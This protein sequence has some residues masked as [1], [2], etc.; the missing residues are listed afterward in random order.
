M[1]SASTH[2]LA[3]P[4]TISSPR[5]ARRLTIFRIVA[6]IMAVAAVGG[7]V[8]TAVFGIVNPAQAPH[9]FHNAVVAAL[10]IV[11]S[12]PPVIVALRA[13][14]RATRAL[15]ILAVLALAALATMALSLTLDPFT[16]PFVVAIGA[17]WALR[18][19]HGDLIPT[20]RPS[21]LL[22]VLVIAAAAPL[23]TYGVSQAE[24]QRSDHT[25]DHAAFFHWVEASF[26]TVGILLLGVLTALRPAAYRLAGWMAA[27]A[28]A[29]LGAGSLL[30][31]TYAS[32]IETPW[33]WAA[34]GGAIA[35]VAIAEWEARRHLAE[36][37][38]HRL[39]A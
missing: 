17:L 19:P 7:G 15:T 32:A 35:F 11:L 20:G 5:P 4:A 22:L 9:A 37:V 30:L 16:L 34:L 39:R 28:L 25:S 21:W 2:E 18:P 13:P 31:P 14:E 1:F 26:Y 6:T 38:L 10:L 3:Q 33:A 29:V 24:L 8:F 12:A 36:H 27:V 23:V